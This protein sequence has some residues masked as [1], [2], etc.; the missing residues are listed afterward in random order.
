M[1][2]IQ[3]T[4]HRALF[5]RPSPSIN[6]MLLYLAN[7]VHLYFSGEFLRW[8]DRSAEECIAAQGKE[9]QISPR[10]GY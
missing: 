5:P 8:S 6:L 4:N 9:G 7:L 10:K 3:P 2:T 1:F